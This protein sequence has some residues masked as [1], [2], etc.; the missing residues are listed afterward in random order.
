[1]KKYSIYRFCNLEKD[2]IRLYI[3]SYTRNN[4][5]LQTYEKLL[6]EIF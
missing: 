6:E 4:Q 3:E 2:F 1:M 5:D